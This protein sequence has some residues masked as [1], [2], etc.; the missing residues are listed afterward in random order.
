MSNFDATDALAINTIRTLSMDAI[1]KANSGHPGLPMGAAP[2]AYVLWQKHLKH[3]P[4]NPKWPDRDRFVLSAGHGSM[5]LYS[6]LHLSG[7]ELSLDEIKNFR[8]WGSKTPGHPESFVTPGVECTTGPL[9]QGCVNA[10]GMAI[11]ERYMASLYN[12]DAHTIVDHFTYALVGDGDLMEGISAEAASLAGHL[13][14][15]K[16]IYLYDSN[17]ISLDGPT[18]LAFTESVMKRY[19]SCGW[20][21]IRV[22]DGDTDLDAIDA[23]IAEAKAD[24]NR[25]TLIEIKTTIGFGSPNKAGKSAAHGSPLGHD[26][27][28]ASKSAL[29]WTETE[30]FAI[31]GDAA[32]R[33]AIQAEHGQ[34][35]NNEWQA[36]FDAWKNANPQLETTWTHAHDGTLPADWTSKLPQFETG[37]SVA[38][39]SASGKILNGIAQTLPWFIGGDA[40]LSCSTKTAI[41]DGG[42]FNAVDNP[43]GRNIHYGVREHAMG[44]IANGMAYHG[45]VHNYTATFFCFLDYMKPAVRLAAL[46][47]LPVTFVFTHDS[48]G[49]GEDGPTHQPIEHLASLRSLP[50]TVTLRPCDA[51]ETEE[52]WKIA[53]ERKDGPTVLVLSRQNLPILD[54]QA[55]GTDGTQKGAY[56]LSDAP[57]AAPEVILMST[58]AEVHLALEAQAALQAEGTATRV[59]SMP[60]WELFEAQDAS[61]QESVLPTQVTRRVAIEAGSSLGWHRWVG[62][63]G[64]I[65]AVDKFGASAPASTIFKEYGFSVENVVA[66]VKETA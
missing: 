60:S 7:Y 11:A 64:K 16:L 36:N 13:K 53:I 37:G 33:F 23:A 41:S 44:A 14:L 48:I 20:Q 8:Q 54:A 18:D 15:G 43:G 28:Q 57:N 40:D 30:T 50:N 59:V 9:G 17:D 21:V 46:N 62:S 45:G 31:P 34:A 32:A 10:V 66:K 25:P 6:M 29:G 24:T 49:L 27:I 52:A 12:T 2:M 35:I 55:V 42:S 19:E 4:K 63:Q 26:E 38:T 1:Q 65:I 61:Y 51:N 56:I 39:R 5:L 22:E 47:H 3:N 58:G